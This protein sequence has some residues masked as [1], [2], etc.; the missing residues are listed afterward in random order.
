MCRRD[1]WG[2]RRS[3]IKFQGFLFLAP[4]THFSNEQSEQKM[5]AFIVKHEL[6][7][8]SDTLCL[9]YLCCLPSPWVKF[10][11]H[12]REKYHGGW[13]GLCF[14]QGHLSRVVAFIHRGLNLPHESNKNVWNWQGFRHRTSSAL[15]GYLQLFECISTRWNN[16]MLHYKMFIQIYINLNEIKQRE[17]W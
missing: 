10:T 16:K 6:L 9:D 15:T 7:I 1:T 3:S 2:S 17:Y 11:Y 14:A 8:K 5:W 4:D 12:D 13:Y